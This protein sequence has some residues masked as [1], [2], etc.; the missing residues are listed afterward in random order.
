MDGKLFLGVADNNQCA[1]AVVGDS[2][3]RIVATSV[4]G[5]VNHRFYGISRARENL[6][7][8]LTKT[9]GSQDGEC[10]E[11]VCFT[12][13]SDLVTSDLEMAGVVHGV[14]QAREIRV[15]NFARSCTLGMRTEKDR[16]LLVGGQS[17]LVVFQNVAGVRFQV[18]EDPVLWDLQ[19]RLNKK[20]ESESQLNGC[21]ELHELLKLDWTQPG[22]L[23][24]AVD[25]MAR[26]GNPLALELVHDIA[27]DLVSLV[28]KM[29]QHFRSF[30]P[31][32]GL[33]GQVLLGSS[34][35]YERVC[36]LIAILFPQAQ[37][38]EATL[39][40]AKGAYLSTLVNRKSSVEPEVMFSSPLSLG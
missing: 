22:E 34:L 3:G 13:K 18:R 7:D 10:L 31:V 37:V 35:V 30:D 33:Y 20:L 9:M 21:G 4:G 8:L 39:A 26:A 32:I 11:R 2:V 24:G 6:R 25:Q 38:R 29:A 12:Y 16:M 23:I 17:G 1:V 28:V 19:R 5:S 15:E 36:H 40:P 14:I 27:Y